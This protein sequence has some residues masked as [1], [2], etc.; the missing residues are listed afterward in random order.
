MGSNSCTATLGPLVIFQHPWGNPDAP[1]DWQ[2][3]KADALVSFS[4]IGPTRTN[5]SLFPKG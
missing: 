4:S 1:I 5:L 2:T 3:W